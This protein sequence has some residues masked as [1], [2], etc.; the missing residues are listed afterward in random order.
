M[1][2]WNASNINWVKTEVG[3]QFVMLAP[4]MLSTSCGADCLEGVKALI[5]TES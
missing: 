2:L 1:A 4:A 5:T 3:L